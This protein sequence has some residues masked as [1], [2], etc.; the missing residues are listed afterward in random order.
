MASFSQYAIFVLSFLLLYI[1]FPANGLVIRTPKMPLPALSGESEVGTI[2]L[3]L[4][5]PYTTDPFAPGPR[6]ILVQVFY[7]ATDTS[8][9]PFAPYMGPVTSAFY[10]NYFHI[11]NGSLSLLQPNAHAGAPISCVDEP[12]VILFSTSLGASR[13]VYTTL[14]E[15]LASHGFIVISIDHP[16]D[17][18]LVEFPDGSVVYSAVPED[19]T[20]ADIEMFSDLRLKDTVF[21][22]NSL[23]TIIES[24]PAAE[25]SLSLGNIGIFGHSFG[26]A[27]AASLMFIDDRVV[28]GLNM[29]GM[30][31]G[32]VVSEGLDKPFLIMGAGNHFRTAYA[33]WQSF[34]D[35][36]RG[37][38]R[39][40]HLADA[41]HMVFSDLPVVVEL[42]G[43]RDSPMKEG[44]ESIIG[45]INGTRANEVQRAYITAFF[46]FG[47]R[48]EAGPLLD[49]PDSEYQEMMF[50]D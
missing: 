17:A 6:S 15:D 47:L 23:S 28:A 8:G 1:S 24:I 12:G 44:L 27:I 22:L 38:K 41:E 18:D 32:P 16:Y 40:L 7:P 37:W 2:V 35:N 29:D 11:T 19:T 21:T 20:D 36:Q 3:K 9:Y 13:T 30:L 4:T 34:W 45:T 33:T 14:A 49:G 31:R 46:E 50:L 5:D 43:L 26:G 42:L 48:G 10:E 39:E 25:H